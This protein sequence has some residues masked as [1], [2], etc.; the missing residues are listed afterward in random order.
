MKSDRN[1]FT[2]DDWV[3][4]KLPVPPNCEKLSEGRWPFFWNRNTDRL[5]D[6]EFKKI[7]KEQ[8]RAFFLAIEKQLGRWKTKFQKRIES[9]SPKDHEKL[10]KNERSKIEQFWRNQF[11]VFDYDNAITKKWQADGIT[12]KNYDDILHLDNAAPI[13]KGKPDPLFMA[14]L[15]IRYND[16]LE[17]VEHELKDK[18]SVEERVKRAYEIYHKNDC[19]WPDAVEIFNKEMKSKGETGYKNHKSLQAAHNRLKKEGRI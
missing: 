4:E 7:T 1:K 9:A 19:T 18:I 8:K 15:Y 16:Y 10:I 3:N 14:H 13:I 5:S 6:E 17:T 2:F 11:S 12:P